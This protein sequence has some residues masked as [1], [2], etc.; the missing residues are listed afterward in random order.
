MLLYILRR[1]LLLIPV[2]IG[3]SLVTFTISH[4]IPA[5]PAQVAAGLEAGPE[6]VEALRELM[7]LNKPLC[8]QYMIYL[9]GL[10]R[11]DL[12][13]SMRTRQPVLKDILRY[14]PATLE[15]AV[16]TMLVYVLVGVPLGIV[17]AV[18]KGKILDLLTRMF[19]ISGTAM[20][21]FWL[22]LLFQ[23]L[24]FR[25]LNILP[26]IGRLD[27]GV[28][29][30][31]H[32]TGMYIFD[33]FVTGQWATFVSSLKHAALPIMTLVLGRLAVAVRLTRASM[34]EVLAKDYVRTAMA[35]GLK[36][37]IVIL[38]HAFRNALIPIVTILGLQFGWLLGGAVLVEVI[39]SWP[40]MGQYGVQSI[41]MLDFAP[42]MGIAVVSAVVFTL[43]NL[44]MDLIYCF[45]DPR[46]RW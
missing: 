39:F 25:Q 13:L 44:G 23:L 31:P 33:S 43:L 21:V 24:F 27:I 3:I 26:A 32:I 1:F 36:G 40:G 12:G 7:G 38:K 14:F 19:A 45:L 6:Q 15:L 5:D 28:T 37:R 17:S 46:I 42:I 9:R 20:P 35:K 2:I 4:V 10:L 29:P 11:G 41:A 8:V 16:L 18:S 22:G 30:P 34:L